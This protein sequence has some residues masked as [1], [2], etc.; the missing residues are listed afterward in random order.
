M[1]YSHVSLWNISW[2][3]IPFYYYSAVVVVVF[4]AGGHLIIYAAVH[5]QM[6]SIGWEDCVCVRFC[7]I[8]HPPP[9]H[10]QPHAIFRGL[11][12]SIYLQLFGSH[13]AQWR[14]HDCLVAFCYLECLASFSNLVLVS[15]CFH[16]FTVQYFYF[17]FWLVLKNKKWAY[18]M[19]SFSLFGQ[20]SVFCKTNLC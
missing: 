2:V 4:P 12:R 7:F 8:T 10:G 18:V 16:P 5:W 19:F 11:L 14:T 13:V 9:P 20:L 3:A 6:H 17:T 1:P 15:F